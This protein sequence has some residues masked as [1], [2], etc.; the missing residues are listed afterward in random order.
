MAEP[1][2]SPPPKRERD[3]DPASAALWDARFSKD[4]ALARKDG[5]PKAGAMCRKDL[6]PGSELTNGF[7]TDIHLEAEVLRQV[8][9][10]D[11]D[12]PPMLSPQ[13]LASSASSAE[14]PLKEPI[15]WSLL[16]CTTWASTLPRLRQRVLNIGH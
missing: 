7:D 4:A 5:A 14:R 9:K 15:P 16:S 11:E 10:S 12:R 1:A 13:M 2:P 8:L 6:P 3:F